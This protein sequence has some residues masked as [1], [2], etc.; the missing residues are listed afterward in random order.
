MAANNSDTVQLSVPSSGSGTFEIRGCPLA[1]YANGIPATVDTPLRNVPVVNGTYR[2]DVCVVLSSGVELRT[3]VSGTG[4]GCELFPFE[5]FI[6]LWLTGR[7]TCLLG[8]ADGNA[9]NDLSSPSGGNVTV[10]G[11]RGAVAY[12]HCTEWCARSEDN[13]LFVYDDG[14]GHDTY[15]HCDEPISFF[16]DCSVQCSVGMQ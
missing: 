12:D 13:S 6:P 9:N 10:S 5:V 14:E 16:C 15:N 2:Y 1:L 3:R 11:T 4:S 7:L 8:N